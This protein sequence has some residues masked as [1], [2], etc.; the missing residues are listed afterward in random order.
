MTFS[1]SGCISKV[2]RTI[3][4]FCAIQTVMKSSTRATSFT[5][6]LQTLPAIWMGLLKTDSALLHIPVKNHGETHYNSVFQG[7]QSSAN[8]LSRT[9]C[10]K[11]D[12]TSCVEKLRRINNNITKLKHIISQNKSDFFVHFLFFLVFL[13]SLGPKK[14]NQ[15]LQSSFQLVWWTFGPAGSHI[16]AHL[17]VHPNLSVFWLPPAPEEMIP[18]SSAVNFSMDHLLAASFVWWLADAGQVVFSGF[19]ERFSLQ[20]AACYCW[21]QH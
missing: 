3:T 5:W 15:F 10:L 17:N 9:C 2:A 16:S 14:A 21:K 11:K 12:K 8:L 19:L 7:T 1:D 20:T 18:G 13:A 4:V 6:G